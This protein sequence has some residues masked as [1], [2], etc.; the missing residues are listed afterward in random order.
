MN[1]K[2]KFLIFVILFIAVGS[3]YS[4]E[5]Y[6]CQE[7]RNG[8][9][10]GVSDVFTM[11]RGGGYLT[12][13]FKSNYAIG[14]RKVEIT[15][16]KIDGRYEELIDTMPFDVN[17]DWDYIFFDDIGFDRAG[18]YKVSLYKMNGSVIATGYVEIVNG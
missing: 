10:I 13:M 9:E 16:T 12:V 3:L 15:V 18:Y 7:Y 6:F 17:P 14:E 8:E 1:K 11:D 5:L 4:Q 2:I